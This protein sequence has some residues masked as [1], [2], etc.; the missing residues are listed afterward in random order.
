MIISIIGLLL[1][2]INLFLLFKHKKYNQEHFNEFVSILDKQKKYNSNCLNSIENN[3]TQIE[4]KSI[5]IESNKKYI[6]D[7]LEHFE[8]YLKEYKL[9]HN[10]FIDELSKER[11]LTETLR[12]P[13]NKKYHFPS[14]KKHKNND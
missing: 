8:L 12:E 2:I 6:K 9:K 3:K 13:L 11:L 5:H 10:S 14:I 7:R 4:S 1:G